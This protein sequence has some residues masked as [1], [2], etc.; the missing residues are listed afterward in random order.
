MKTL[1]CYPRSQQLVRCRP[2]SPWLFEAALM[3]VP[4]SMNLVF[5][6]WSL[7]L[8]L[9]LYL[10]CMADILR[11]WHNGNPG[12]VG[13]ICTSALYWLGQVVRCLL[14]KK[15]LVVLNC[16]KTLSLSLLAFYWIHRLNVWQCTCIVNC[17]AFK[18][19][20][21]MYVDKCHRGCFLMEAF[22]LHFCSLPHS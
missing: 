2:T 19:M 7:Q 5:S 21:L 18:K 10:P 8:W 12:W 20:C 9:L 4:G 13:S 16:G 14:K 22:C 6:H 17:S 3:T 1:P 15:P 11:F